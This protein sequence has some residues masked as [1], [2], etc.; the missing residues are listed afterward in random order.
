MVEQND[1]I[2]KVRDVDQ[3]RFYL[4]KKKLQQQLKEVLKSV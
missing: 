3:E 2:Q 4:G 1:K